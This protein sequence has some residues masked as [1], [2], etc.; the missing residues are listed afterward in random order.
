MNA[1]LRQLLAEVFE[2]TPD[3]IRETDSQ[4]TLPTWDSLRHLQLVMALEQRFGIQI[5]TE[6]IAQL[7]T[8]ADVARVVAAGRR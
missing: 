7:K 3:K 6:Q 4:A 2:T 8:V 5:D 1:D